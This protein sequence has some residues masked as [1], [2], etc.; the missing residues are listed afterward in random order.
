[1]E[2]SLYFYAPNKGA[3]VVFAFFFWVSCVIHIWQS[4]R[5]NSWKITLMLSWCSLTF[6]AGY[7]L[8]EVGAYNYSNVNVYIASMVIIY[9]VPPLYEMSNYQI[10]SRL[11]YYVPYHSPIHPGRMLTTLAGISTVVETLN[12]NGVS[13]SAN[14]KL[15][16]TKQDM[17]KTFLK[18][19]LIV[20]LVV[21]TGFVS[22]TGFFHYKCRK[23]GPFPKNIK[24]GIITLYCSSALIGVRTIYR[25]VEYYSVSSLRI[26]PSMNSSSV[27]PIIR[28]EAFFWVFEA[29][30][31][32]AN[33]FLMNIRHPMRFLPRDSRIYLAEDGTTETVGP[34]YEDTRFFL[35]AIVDPFD[36]IGLIIGRHMKKEFWKTNANLK[37]D[38]GSI[39]TDGAVSGK[40]NDVE[41]AV[42]AN[43]NGSGN[44][45]DIEKA[46]DADA[47]ADADADG[48][49]SGHASEHNV[50]LSTAGP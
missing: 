48:V 32:L 28:Y 43:M 29:L 3:P 41:K 44:G 38:S 4:S 18:A 37:E 49:S 19:A 9:S 1:M 40:E 24:G 33:S 45:K 31:M 8:R 6:G 16:K 27:S 50:S 36:L 25:T 20:Q 42:G 21:L 26:T 15:S 12:G 30:L 39:T 11:F 23:N 5:Y 34:G 14:I 46:V 17:G 10:L 13:Y 35:I 2:G 47:D 7:V 22:L